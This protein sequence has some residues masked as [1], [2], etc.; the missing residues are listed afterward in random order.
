[1]RRHRCSG[2]S[3]CRRSSSKRQQ[4]HLEA[5]LVD[6]PEQVKKRVAARKPLP[7]D[8]IGKIEIPAIGV[9]EYVV[10]GTDTG[11][12]RKG[13][14]HYPDT[15]LPGEKRHRRDR[16]SPDHLRGAVPRCRQAEARDR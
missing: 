2:R 9:S 13:P 5:P 7:G 12:L 8:A 6:P 1:M 11:N 4:T 16:R 3:R 10:E 15:P 14:G